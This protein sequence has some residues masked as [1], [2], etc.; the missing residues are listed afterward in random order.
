M[1]EIFVNLSNKNN[2]KLYLAAHKLKIMHKSR[3]LLLM[4]AVLITVYS[5]KKDTTTVVETIPPEPLSDVVT[6]NAEEI[7]V[8]LKTHTYNYEEFS[9]PSTDFNF[10]IK[11]DTLIEGSEKKSLFELATPKKLAVTSAYHGIDSE[12]VV[13]FTYYY[14]I[15]REGAGTSPTVADS[16]LVKYKGQLL[17][18]RVFDQSSSYLW[19]Y[20]P[21]T[22]RGYYDG[23]SMLKSGTTVVQNEDGTS[24]YADSGIGLFVFPSALAYYSGSKG[25]ISTYE[26]LIF[27]LELGNYVP[28]TDYDGDGIPSILED[29]NG[30]GIVTNDNTDEDI[31]L[32]SYTPCTANH[33]DSDDDNDG[34]PT[35]DEIIINEDGSISFPDTDGDGIPD[36]L[37]NV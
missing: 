10:E 27:T 23:V 17:D 5:C 22:I 28:D 13:D 20:L 34:I 7:D 3:L 8:F 31:E 2:G 1:S 37:D 29:L 21:M 9:A 33:F 15:A 30:D 6:V 25:I 36:Y 11:I 4:S 35:K 14:I 26:N 19:Q 18:G 16:T 12:E 32:R 24:S